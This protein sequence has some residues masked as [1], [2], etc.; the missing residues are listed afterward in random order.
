MSKQ[1]QV[2]IIGTAGRN[3]DEKKL[4]PAIFQSMVDEARKTIVETWKLD[5]ST[6]RLVSGGSAWA[7]HVA[8]RLYGAKWGGLDLHLPEAW[9]KTQFYDTRIVDWKSNPGGTLNYYHRKFSAAMPCDSLAEIA[10]L[11]KDERVRF[12]VHDGMHQRNTAVAARA[13]YLIAFTFAAKNA[14][15][16]KDGGTADTWIKTNPFTRKLHISLPICTV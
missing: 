13:N 1:Q 11:Q 3:D 12:I 8:V 4:S 10:A 6:V 5:P 7:D 16:P 2:A 9:D 14:K 15:T